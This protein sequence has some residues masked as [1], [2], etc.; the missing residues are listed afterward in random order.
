[1]TVITDLLTELDHHKLPVSFHSYLWMNE[2]KEV[3][4]YLHDQLF[5]TPNITSLKEG[6]QHI[7][8]YRFNGSWEKEIIEAV[9]YT[10]KEKNLQKKRNKT[11]KEQ[12]FE[13]E[14]NK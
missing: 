13:Q 1:M 14:I 11:K 6:Q 5:D 10:L 7:S 2:Y 3:F 8:I 4:Y 9:L 12:A